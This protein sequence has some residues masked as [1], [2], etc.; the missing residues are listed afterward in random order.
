MQ[1]RLNLKPIFHFEQS[2]QNFEIYKK[3]NSTS[4]LATKS[5]F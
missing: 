3:T 1:I 4:F 5:D 2:E